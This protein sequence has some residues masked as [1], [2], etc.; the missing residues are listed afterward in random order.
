VKYR[1]GQVVEQRVALGEAL[2]EFAEEYPDL[3]V[4]DPDVGP[5]T[6]TEYFKKSFPG[7]FYEVGIAE[8]NLVGI[9]AGLAT[10]G[11]IPFVS[12]FAVFL[13]HRAG[14]QVRNSVAHPRANVK[15]NGAY[16]GLPT[17]RAG[18]THSSF[19]DLALMRV[20]PN[21]VVFEPADAVEVRLFLKLALEIK[22]P[23]YLRTVRCGVPV[24]FDEETHKVET[25]KSVWLKHGSDI[26]LI[27]TGMMTPRLLNVAADL[28]KRGVSVNLIHMPCIKP[29]DREAVIQAAKTGRIVTVENHSVIGGLGSAVAEVTA[30]EACCLVKRLGFQDIFLESGNDET[31][32]DQYGLSERKI[33]DEILLTLK[34][35]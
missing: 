30:E 9:S 27:S 35:K 32:F 33:L 19:E 17:G 26:S 1:I 20:L 15:L 11:Y 24:I 23:V 7:R 16:G 22:G 2:V 13:T 3:V 25:G 12:A 21:M 5:S 10:M 18:A 34:R 29:I 31:L 4:L 28:E 6:R 14:D 8:Q